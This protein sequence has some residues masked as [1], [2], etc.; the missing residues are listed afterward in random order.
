ME[1]NW[2]GF[3]NCVEAERQPTRRVCGQWRQAAVLICHNATSKTLPVP[4]PTTVAH[5]LYSSTLKSRSLKRYGQC[6]SAAL[7]A[8]SGDLQ[9]RNCFYNRS[10]CV[11]NANTFRLLRLAYFNSKQLLVRI[12]AAGY[13]LYAAILIKSTYIFYKREVFTLP[14][15]TLRLQYSLLYSLFI[16]SSRQG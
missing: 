10:G 15:I 7:P 11:L 13:A 9:Y 12:L 6:G 4:T 5:F 14:I 2:L 8:C 1:E 3:S 16:K